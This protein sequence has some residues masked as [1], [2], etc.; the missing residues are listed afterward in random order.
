MDGYHEG[1]GSCAGILFYM[2]H[3]IQEVATL[4]L[5]VFMYRVGLVVF[6][7][8]SIFNDCSI[9]NSVGPSRSL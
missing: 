3:K 9:H 5:M 1:D 8:G 2:H 4:D 6:R 7:V